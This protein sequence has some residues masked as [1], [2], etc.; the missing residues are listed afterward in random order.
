MA[1]NLT[2]SK[3]LEGMDISKPHFR[4][5]DGYSGSVDSP[6][7]PPPY[8]SKTEPGA[9]TEADED[10]FN[11]FLKESIERKMNGFNENN[12]INVKLIEKKGWKGIF[13]TTKKFEVKGKGGKYS[14]EVK[15]DPSSCD[16]CID[17]LFCGCLKKPMTFNVKDDV[18][19][20][21]FQF[22]MLANCFGV[23]PAME[24]ITG[25]EGKLVG[26][27]VKNWSVFLVGQF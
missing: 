13:F 9:Q 17:L 2:D 12:L 20:N 8:E 24:I 14:A 4:G 27:I 22:R 7:A 21:V 23:R 11:D 25:D 1:D 6:S 18:G 15:T 10:D 26:R 5:D 3:N 19:N 16:C